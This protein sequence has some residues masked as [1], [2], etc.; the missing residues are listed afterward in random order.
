MYECEFE[1]DEHGRHQGHTPEEWIDN[2]VGD[3]DKFALEMRWLMEL[4]RG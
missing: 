3:K 2:E 1:N 4:P